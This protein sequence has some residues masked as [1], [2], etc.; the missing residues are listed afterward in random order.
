MNTG[1][2]RESGGGPEVGGAP[3]ALDSCRNH[4]AI[5]KH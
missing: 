4:F 1:S 3:L 2:L 5:H